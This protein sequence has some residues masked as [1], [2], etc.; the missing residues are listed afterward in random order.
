MTSNAS[1]PWVAPTRTLAA[2]VAALFHAEPNVWIDGRTLSTIAGCYGWRTRVSDCRRQF[3]MRIV[4]RQRRVKKA[5]GSSYV[6]SEYRYEPA[7]QTIFLELLDDQT[8]DCE[9]LHV[10]SAQQAAIKSRT[11]AE[12]AITA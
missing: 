10:P 7:G 9:V 11:C 1:D 12:F 5:D 2:K 3:G 4:N 6:V 8:E